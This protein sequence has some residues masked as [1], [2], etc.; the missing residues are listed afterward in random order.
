MV[1]TALL[2]FVILIL[3]SAK[4]QLAAHQQA[5]L[6]AHLVEVNALWDR[7][8]PT[9]GD[10]SPT[11]FSDEVQRIATHLHLVRANLLARTSEGWTEGQ[12]LHRTR[13]LDRLGDY[14]D[15]GTF[16]QNHVLPAR[17]PVFIDPYGTAC[18]V[19]W[20]M[21][22]SGHRELA[23]E[24]SAHMNLAYVLD[25]P[26]TPLWPSISEWAVT[27]GFQADELA[28]IQP[29][30]PP[31]VPWA[32]LDGGTDGPVTVLHTLDNGHVLVCGSFT[33]AGGS[34]AER[35]AL[36]NGTSLVPMGSG[37]NGTITCAVEYNGEVYVGGNMFNGISDLA[38]W[39]G[40]SWEFSVVFSGKLPHI[41][42]L[43]VHDGMLHA[44][45][46][47]MGFAGVDHH[48][49]R[50]TGG[51]WVTMGDHF[52]D[53]VLA[54]ESFNGELV[55][56]G[57]FTQSVSI[58][59][60]FMPHVARFDG[61]GWSQLGDGLDA[62]VR[63]LLTVDGTLHAGGDLYVNVLPTFGLARITVGANDWQHVLP[64]HVDYI[65]SGVGPSYIASLAAHDGLIYFAGQFE[66]YFLMLMGNHIAS[67]NGTPDGVEPLAYLDQHVHAT[68]VANDR[69]FMGG[70]F[71]AWLPYVA[72][73]DIST[74]LNDPRATELMTMAPV[75][76]TDELFIDVADTDTRA[77][78]LEFLDAQG[79][80]VAV[81]LVRLGDRIRADV[82]ALPAG[83]YV[84]HLRMGDRVGTGRFIK[85]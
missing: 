63:D 17:N 11:H 20:L 67:F 62:S 8:D 39:N 73:V 27:H 40:S 68:A 46:E 32:P 1:R 79:R 57:M 37:L 19:G 2:L 13:L 22:E 3:T 56:G 12:V 53:R 15:A 21:I 82:S 43:H 16:P 70:E 36:W 29:G 31:A 47:T 64:G 34:A 69:L 4:A 52:N 83:M 65:S 5:P 81:P 26:S 61:T 41:N 18:A 74:S 71:N 66:M 35:V 51:G 10:V 49:M 9:R 58:T 48:V 45:G 6:S 85:V 42:A 7:M 23:E 54:L 60:P 75:P 14:A 28:W 44:A 55:A 77:A 78:V 25:M 80:T 59:D 24:I 33:E 38:K 76:T 84:V 30:Y 72:A 50:F